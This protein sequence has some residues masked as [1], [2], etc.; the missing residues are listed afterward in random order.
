[1]QAN[2]LVCAGQNG[3]SQVGLFPGEVVSLIHPT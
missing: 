3:G 2:H 1:L